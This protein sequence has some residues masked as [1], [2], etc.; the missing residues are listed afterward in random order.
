MI[1]LYVAGML[2]PAESAELASTWP[3]AVPP[4][5]AITPKPRPRW[6]CSPC[7]S[8]RSRLGRR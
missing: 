6:R 7:R 1:L 2:D 8:L 4:A 5:L 3:A